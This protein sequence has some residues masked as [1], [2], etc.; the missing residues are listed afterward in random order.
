MTDVR[1]FQ[2]GGTK[3]V[4]LGALRH[5]SASASSAVEVERRR[6]S[7]SLNAA[8]GARGFRPSRAPQAAL[9]ASLVCMSMDLYFI[10]CV[11]LIPQSRKN[12]TVEMGGKHRCFQSPRVFF[13]R[14][15]STFSGTLCA[16][17][18][19]TEKSG[20]ETALAKTE[21]CLGGFGRPCLPF[22]P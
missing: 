16:E 6:R 19:S 18:K 8:L 7:R 21:S 22:S 1:V 14:G 17:T 13:P 3:C 10:S 11:R 9:K 20:E 12:P 2:L 15:P 4:S 5:S